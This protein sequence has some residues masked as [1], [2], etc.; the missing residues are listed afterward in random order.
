MLHYIVVI[1]QSFIEFHG[2]KVV[3]VVKDEY[4]T[5]K[6]GGFSGK[7]RLSLA[8]FVKKS[9]DKKRYF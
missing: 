2:G 5:R 4:T 3:K 9:N 7:T 8:F 1:I 6:Q